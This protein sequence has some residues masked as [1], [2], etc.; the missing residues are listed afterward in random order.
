MYIYI[1]IKIEVGNVQLAL[2]QK[3][4]I[5]WTCS[6]SGGYQQ[7]MIQLKF[8]REI[9]QLLTSCVDTLYMHILR[10]I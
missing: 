5:D 1:E 10:R 3:I 2:Q 8:L 6:A 9:G 4:V 7:K